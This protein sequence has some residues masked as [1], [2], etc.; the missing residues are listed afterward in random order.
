MPYRLRVKMDS[1]DLV[2][3]SLREAIQSL[4][5]FEWRGGGSFYQWLCRITDH[6]MIRKLR[7]F[8]ALRRDAK[9]EISM[10]QPGTASEN[11]P[12]PESK[13]TSPD[14]LI[15]TQEQGQVLRREIEQLSDAH[16]RVLSLSLEGLT[17]QE[18]ADKMGISAD[19]A[20]RL[21]M[22]AVRKLT[23]R[24]KQVFDE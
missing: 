8:G 7:Y 3:T 15:M 23:I 24:L 4:D 20:W 17:D 10:D 18:V 5:R 14:D 2:Q 11:Q 19:A 9:R 12:E 22:A 6:K 16:H 1:S 21:R 13:G